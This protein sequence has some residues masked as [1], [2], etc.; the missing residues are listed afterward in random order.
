MAE[1]RGM[2]QRQDGMGGRTMGGYA[3]GGGMGRDSFGMRGGGGPMDQRMMDPRM[4]GPMGGGPGGPFGRDS[5][6]ARMSLKDMAARTTMSYDAEVISSMRRTEAYSV[7]AE[8]PEITT[9]PQTV[10]QKDLKLLVKQLAQAAKLVKTTAAQRPE[11]DI[12]GSVHLV[13]D[14]ETMRDLLNTR[15]TPL[16]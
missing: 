11:G 6:V 3:Y 16:P 2:R 7:M 4:R 12:L 15:T 10:E 14:N 13:L 9:L 1:A 8:K 5:A